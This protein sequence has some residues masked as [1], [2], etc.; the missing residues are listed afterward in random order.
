MKLKDDVHFDGIVLINNT[1]D[2]VSTGRNARKTESG[3]I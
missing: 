3:A 2:D 1:A